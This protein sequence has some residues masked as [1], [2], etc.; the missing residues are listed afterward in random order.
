MNNWHLYYYKFLAVVRG[1]P[2]ILDRWV[3]LYAVQ[4]KKMSGL[5]VEHFQTDTQRQQLNRKPSEKL[6]AEMFQV[7]YNTVTGAQL[8]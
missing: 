8:P 5:F 2:L 7:A 1:A 3:R 6:R 4:V